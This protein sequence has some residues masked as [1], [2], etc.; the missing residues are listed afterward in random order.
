MPRRTPTLLLAAAL[1]SGA[2]TAMFVPAAG[3]LVYAPCASSPAFSCT[4]VPVPLDRA[5]RVPGTLS[6]GVERKQASSSPSQDA[7]IALAGGP[8]QA[9]LPLGEF[10]AKALA[11]A[12]VTRDLLVFDQRGTGASNPLS[13]PA[14]N[15]FS[16]DPVS[17]VFERCALEVGP[18]RGSYTTQESVQDIES[19]RQAAGYE[20]LVLYGTSYGTKVAEEYA[21]RYPLHVEALVLDSV[22]PLNGSEPFSVPTFQAIGSV[23]AE[24]CSNHACAGITSNPVADIA[25]LT[26][27]LR[28]RP[29]KGSVYDGS[30]RRHGATLNESGLL[31]I[32]EAG[33]L[34]PALRA[35]LPGAVRSAL[36]NDPDPLLRLQLL[37]EG[38]IPNLPSSHRVEESSMAIDEALFVTTTCEEAPFPW[39]RSGTPTTRLAEAL[40]ALHALPSTDFYPFD[41]NTALGSSLV[42]ACAGWPD[43]SPAPPTSGSLPNVPALILS[44]AQDL[45]TPTSN[46][47]QVAA[48][49]PDAQLLVV[50]F[51]GH[52]VIGSDFSGCAVQ[53][54]AAFFSNGVVGHPI[55]PCAASLDKF[56]PTPITPTKLVYVHPAPGLSGKPGL[57]LTA[58]LDTIVDIN[59]QVIGATLQADQ[60][61]PSGASFGGLRGGDAKLSASRLE[62]NRFSFVPGVQLSGTFGVKKGVLQTTTLRIS[63]ATASSGTVRVGSG[64]KQVTGTLGGKRFDVNIAKVRLSRAGTNSPEWTSAPVG[65]PLPGLAH[66]R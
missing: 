49:I 17:Q 9:A 16:G 31:G 46:A 10:I 14:L 60:E 32:L 34:N 8:G 64:N 55:L 53:A 65:F 30:G 35:L 54:L 24:L 59:R 38:L 6:L 29:L 26:A 52:S 11:P 48:L 51:T 56:A 33:D 42:S 47:R 43:A 12:L 15:S 20:K 27:Q 50:P 39:Q 22:V 19:I 5:G 45:R 57:T 61:L 23:L 21:E 44:G 13:C 2:L 37:A 1:L 36:R 25:S 41:A 40:G 3:A 62:L 58:V 18:A 7:V 4:T 66:L 63:G 28:K